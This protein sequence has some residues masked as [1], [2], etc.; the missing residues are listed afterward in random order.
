MS[1]SSKKTPDQVAALDCWRAAPLL[2]RRPANTHKEKVE[3]SFLRRAHPYEPPG[4]TDHHASEHN[5]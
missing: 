3:S 2:G 1:S 5:V 4:A